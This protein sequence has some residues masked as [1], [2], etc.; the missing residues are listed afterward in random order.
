MRDDEQNEA[1]ASLFEE[2]LNDQLA[3]LRSLLRDATAADPTAIRERAAEIH[4]R[5]VRACEEGF[6]V[7]AHQQDGRLLRIQALGGL[8]GTRFLFLPFVDPAAVV[9][10]Q[11]CELGKVERFLVVRIERASIA[12]PSR[13]G[14]THQPN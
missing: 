14:E 10:T 2:E 5:L 4:T 3:E 11:Q 7:L 12:F 8:H 9:S 1:K 13:G 6:E